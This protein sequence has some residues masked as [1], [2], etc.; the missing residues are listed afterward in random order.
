MSSVS[1]DELFLY[2]VAK[3]PHPAD[4]YV[5][6]LTIYQWIFPVILFSVLFDGD[7]SYLRTVVYE[8]ASRESS[9]IMTSSMIARC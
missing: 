4:V 9:E 6:L 7:G 3:L 2:D 8:L 5:T 1:Q